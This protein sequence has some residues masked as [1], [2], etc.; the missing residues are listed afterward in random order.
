M[1]ADPGRGVRVVDLGFPDGRI[2]AGL[3]EGCIE[4]LTSLREVRA[5]RDVEN[6]DV[7]LSD[8][9]GSCSRELNLC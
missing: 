7:H 5:A 8:G 1:H 2:D 6:L 3:V 9:R 4:S